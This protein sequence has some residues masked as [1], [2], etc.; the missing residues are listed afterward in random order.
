M[1]GLHLGGTG[2]RNSSLYQPFLDEDERE[3]LA[4]DEDD[5]GGG[6][7]GVV[8]FERWSWAPW[9]F[10]VRGG[11]RVT[12]TS[13]PRGGVWR[14]PVRRLLPPPVLPLLPTRPP[15]PADVVVDGAAGRRARPRARPVR[16]A[17]PPLA[18]HQ[19]LLPPRPSP[20]RPPPLRPPRYCRPPRARAG[21]PTHPRSS[22]FLPAARRCYRHLHGSAGGS[23]RGA[24]VRDVPLHDPCL[25]VGLTGR[26]RARQV[27]AR[28]LT[29]NSDI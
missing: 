7:E 1:S 13:H 9:A 3:G 27:Q 2:S 6:L 5:G 26:G 14:V 21:V 19:R 11:R 25:L 10:L 15:W 4:L 17:R 29:A 18:G 24:R 8:L 12:V 20:A 16:P 22:P 28:E 23:V